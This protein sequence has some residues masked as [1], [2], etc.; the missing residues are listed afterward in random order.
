MPILPLSHLH[1]ADGASVGL[2]VMPQQQSSHSP[3]QQE[4]P[5]DRAAA[6]ARGSAGQSY[7]PGSFG[8]FLALT[9]E[10]VLVCTVW[11]LDIP[12]SHKVEGGPVPRLH[13]TMQPRAV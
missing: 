3:P 5:A 7:P 4:Q 1:L 9:V 8:A 13:Y 12:A 6:M 2:Q 11:A 10:F